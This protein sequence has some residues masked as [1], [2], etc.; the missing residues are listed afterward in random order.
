MLVHS[1]GLVRLCRL[2]GRYFNP[3]FLPH[4]SRRPNDFFFRNINITE[5]LGAGCSTDRR[6]FLFSG[7]TRRKVEHHYHDVNL[8]LY[9]FVN[10]FPLHYIA[11]INVPIRIVL[12][13]RTDGSDV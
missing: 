6:F 12:F 11:S 4:G 1:S 2:T 13:H 9:P 7:K 8:D 10:Y 5:L 3:V